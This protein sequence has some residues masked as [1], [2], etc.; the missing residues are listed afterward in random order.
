MLIREWAR[1]PR[2]PQIFFKLLLFAVFA[3]F[4]F[5]RGF[6]SYEVFN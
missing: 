5:I 1:M 6:A 3:A 4:V 2:K